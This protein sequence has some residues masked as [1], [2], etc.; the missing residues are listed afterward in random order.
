MAAI[1]ESTGIQTMEEKML[2]ELKGNNAYEA[3]QYVQSFIARKKRSII[4]ETVS[5]M[6]FHAAK[7][8][9]DY[10]SAGY[11]GTL[12]LWFMDGG[13]GEGNRF[14]IEKEA[15]TL[16][17]GTY[18]DLAR[19]TDFFGSVS[20]DKAAVILDVIQKQVLTLSG[21]LSTDYTTPSGKRVASF[22]EKCAELFEVNH[23]W[24]LAYKFRLRLG[25]MKK[26]A[27]SLDGW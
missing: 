11:T 14:H 4:P 26:V 3:L 19:L 16:G 12:L 7:L 20:Q 27:K 25:D 2:Q 9:V 24:R 22:E 6:V 17:A 21:S 15:A 1:V 18:C 5:S 13:A 23:N 10:D 8:L